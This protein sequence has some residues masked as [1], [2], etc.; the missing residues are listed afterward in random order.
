[1][2]DGLVE[3]HATHPRREHHGHLAGRCR[4]RVEHRDGPLGRLLTD[5]RRAVPL[6]ELEPAAG[7]GAEE[8]GLDRVVAGGDDLGHQPDPGALLLDPAAVGGGDQPL[9]QR[10][11]VHPDHLDDLRA[12][13]AGRVVELTQPGHLVRGRKA[14]GGSV[15]AVHARTHALGQI[16]DRSGRTFLQRGAGGVRG[17]Q[18]RV[19]VQSIGER[20][21]VGGA[22]G[23]ADARTAIESARQLL[24]LAVVQSDRGGCPLL[25]EELGERAATSTSGTQHV[26]DEL[27]G[28]HARD[29]SSGARNDFSNGSQHDHEQEEGERGERATDPSEELI[30]G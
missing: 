2:A 9:L 24:D 13:A 21:A 17:L 30:A 15:R 18:E 12:Q 4:D 27:T 23:H 3:Q 1:M 11:A 29:A 20:I 28:Q 5:G 6:E 7:R 16:D 8:P 26:L 19:P 14:T 10:V 25:D 22:E